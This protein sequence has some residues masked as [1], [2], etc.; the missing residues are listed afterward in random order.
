MIVELARRVSSC[1]W[2]ALGERRRGG[3]ARLSGWQPVGNWV[4]SGA[5]F[6]A[7]LLPVGVI[8]KTSRESGRTVCVG[9]WPRSQ[10]ESD[11]AYRRKAETIPRGGGSFF[12]T[13]AD[14]PGAKNSALDTLFRLN[15]DCAPAEFRTPLWTSGVGCGASASNNMRWHSART[16][17]TIRSCRA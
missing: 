8:P 12:A 17:L 1:G 3:F 6:Q 10:A 15:D 11:P 16:R 9:K 14:A 2:V 4:E 13:A 7:S 5:S